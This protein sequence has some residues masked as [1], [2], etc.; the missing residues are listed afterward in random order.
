MR[1]LVAESRIAAYPCPCSRP[2][3]RGTDVDPSVTANSRMQKL[4]SRMLRA[5]PFGTGSGL[6]H[7]GFQRLGRVAA[8]AGR[9][10]CG[11]GPVL[12]KALNHGLGQKVLHRDTDQRVSPRGVQQCSP[13]RW[14]AML[15]KLG[16]FNALTARATSVTKSSVSRHRRGALSVLTRSLAA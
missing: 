2:L 14:R 4:I 5:R 12:Q 7:A 10:R 6:R 3:S 11:K 13:S 15:A 9:I 8:L 16:G 1:T